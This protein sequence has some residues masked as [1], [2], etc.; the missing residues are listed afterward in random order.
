MSVVYKL[1][2][3]VRYICYK[4][5]FGSCKGIG[6]LGRPLFL[7]NPRNIHL[8]NRVRIFPN[9]R[10]ETHRGGKITICEGVSIGQGLHIT[11]QDFNLTIGKG[12]IMSGNVVITNI[13]HEYQDIT[14]P[15]DAQPLMSKDTQVGENCFIGYGSFIQAGTKLGKHCVVGANSVVS[16]KYEDYSVLV[17]APAKVV[18]RYCFEHK[19][20]I[21]IP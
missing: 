8:S 9:S 18:K 4:L 5:I 3:A 2:W 1:I 7:H 19:R 14:A 16:G 15:V 10:M 6:Y 11:S 13:D 17:G 12:T 21:K 20:W